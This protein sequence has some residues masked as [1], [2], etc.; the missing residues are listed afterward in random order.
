MGE[1]LAVDLLE[2]LLD[3]LGA[4]ARLEIVL[5]LLAHIAVFLLGE[6]I[7]ALERRGAGIGDDIRGKVQDFLKGV[8]RH[9]EQQAHAG[10]DALEIP[11]VAHG[12][13]QFDMAHALA[14]NL[15]LGDLDAAAVADFALVA[16]LLILSAVAF[17][18][19][20]GPE[21]AL[22]EKAVALGLECA[23]ID[24]LRLLDFAVG[25]GKDHFGRSNADL[26]GVKRGVAHYSLSSTSSVSSSPKDFSLSGSSPNTD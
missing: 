3:R 14:A 21:N 23:V 10:R 25:P 9:V 22:A 5:V 4:H 18:V 17:P 24:G 16:D 11:D 26:N 12:R 7:A 2:Q 1:L 15:A 19:L 13:G 8:R 20:R 6:K